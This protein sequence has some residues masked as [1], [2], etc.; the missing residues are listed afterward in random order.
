[1]KDGSIWNTDYA[2]FDGLVKGIHVP[3][4]RFNKYQGPKI[5]VIN[6][7]N[8]WTFIKTPILVVI[9]GARF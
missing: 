3:P 1:M 2:T 9:H 7:K 8:Y 5:G 4:I 6:V